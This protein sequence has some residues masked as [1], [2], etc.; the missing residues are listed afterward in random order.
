MALWKRAVLSLVLVLFAAVAIA[1]SAG[2]AADDPD[3]ACASPESMSAASTPDRRASRSR[4]GSVSASLPACGDRRWSGL[5]GA[6]RTRGRRRGRRVDGASRRESGEDVDVRVD[7]DRE[8]VRRYVDALQERFGFPA[9]NAELVELVKG[10]PG[11]PNRS[12]AVA[13]RRRTMV[14]RI[15]RMLKTRIRPA[16][17]LVMK[18]VKPTITRANF[19]PV[20]VIHR[21]SN[22]LDA[23]QR[24]EARGA[25]SASRPARR[26][27]RRRPGASSI[28]DMQK[29]P[30]WRPPPDSD[31]A[32]GAG[33]DP[34]RAR[35]PAR[36]A[37]DG[38][39]RAARRHP[40][41][42]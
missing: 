25:A 22:R 16:L 38:A 4:R 14:A 2:S 33:A 11:S 31:W 40:R 26:S 36:H 34:A 41:H 37:L 28:V 20:I 1:P 32:Q 5:D 12:G 3:S 9:E 21:G 27:I 24:R 17:P 7:V 42:A 23:L 10:R 13:V 8:Q 29:N 35:Q 18:T 15:T 6:A 39:L 30:W 19:G